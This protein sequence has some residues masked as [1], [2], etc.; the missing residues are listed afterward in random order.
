MH[1]DIHTNMHTDIHIQIQIHTIWECHVFFSGFLTLTHHQLADLYKSVL[2]S[3]ELSE[4]PP[5]VCVVLVFL[6]CW[7]KCVY[8]AISSQNHTHHRRNRR[9]WTPSHTQWMYRI[10][11]KEP[12]FKKMKIVWWTIQICYVTSLYCRFLCI[13]DIIGLIS[14]YFAA[15]V[16]VV[17]KAHPIPANQHTHTLSHRHQTHTCTHTLSLTHTHEH[18]HTTHMHTDIHIQIH[19]HLDWPL[20]G[21]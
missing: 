15:V 5:V 18:T 19:T 8:Y 7:C 1:T 10:F 12:C 13:I 9:S 16:N 14:I 11:S 20:C 6:S 2:Q 21:P 17:T 3:D 4:L